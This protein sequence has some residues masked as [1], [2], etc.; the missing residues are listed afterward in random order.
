M[1][2][3][4][5]HDA[6]ASG[7]PDVKR[8]AVA[9]G[10][11]I[12]SGSLTYRSDMLTRPPP[13][14][15]GWPAVVWLHGPNYNKGWEA[16]YPLTRTDVPHALANASFVTLTF[17]Q[18]GFGL[19]LGEGALFYDRFP[20]WSRLGALVHDAVSAV[21]VL[22]SP[23]GGFHPAGQPDALPRFPT[24]DTARVYLAGHSI[25]GT[26]ALLAGAL[27]G[28]VAGVASLSGWTP[29]RTDTDASRSGGIRRWWQLHATT[30]RLGYF[31]A[32]QA[33]LPVDF[34]AVLALLA[35]KPL[36]VYQPLR[37][38]MNSAA[39]VNAT[40]LAAVADVAGGWP[41]LLLQMPPDRVNGLDAP[42]TSAL[43]KWL[44]AQ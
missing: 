4:Q 5:L 20:R 43:L 27:D 34:D 18:L 7:C 1:D 26:V 35:P 21:D 32:D 40:V 23:Q 33:A 41:S 9:F 11:N 12:I 2:A 24:V 37:D 13:T 39:G 8:T 14:P 42:A 44:A 31:A 3:L 28:R 17:E 22:T 38:R 19:R 25:G 36:L 15:A 16:S 29:L 6:Q 10:P 30:P